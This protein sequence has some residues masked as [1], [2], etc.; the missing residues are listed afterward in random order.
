M[1]NWKEKKSLVIIA[2]IV[3]I[4]SI[5]IIVKFIIN[6]QNSRPQVTPEMQEEMEKIEEVM[7][8]GEIQ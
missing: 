6:I 3:S 4:F 2:G 7:T 1:A 8:K 5:I